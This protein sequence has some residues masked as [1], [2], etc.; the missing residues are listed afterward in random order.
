MDPEHPRP[1]S[2]LCTRTGADHSRSL[3]SGTSLALPPQSR[4]HTTERS[5]GQ[6]TGNCGSK[7]RRSASEGATRLGARTVQEAPW[8]RRTG[9]V[10]FSAWVPTGPSPLRTRRVTEPRMPRSPS[11]GHLSPTWA[12]VASYGPARWHSEEPKPT[13]LGVYPRMSQLPRSPSRGAVRV[14]AT[15]L[16]VSVLVASSSLAGRWRPG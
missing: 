1:A 13:G 3:P 16:Q 15:E 10:H 12:F 5:I 11:R 8:P 7:S 9:Q 2:A 6:S 14:S 4:W